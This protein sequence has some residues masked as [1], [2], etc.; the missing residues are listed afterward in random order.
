[1]L[2]HE[3]FFIIIDALN[4][5]PPSTFTGVYFPCL[6]AQ[7][8]KIIGRAKTRMAE[9]FESAFALAMRKTVLKAPYFTNDNG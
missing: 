6:S 1:M 2:S 7:A 5:S 9:N 4:F 3:M 8:E